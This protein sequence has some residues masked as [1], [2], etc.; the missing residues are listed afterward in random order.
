[1]VWFLEGIEKIHIMKLALLLLTA[2]SFNFLNAQE[3]EANFFYGIPFHKNAPTKLR[4][5]IYKLHEYGINFNLNLPIGE[6]EKW[7]FMGRLGTSLD[8]AYNYVSTDY[9]IPNSDPNDYLYDIRLSGGSVN[10]GIGIARDLAW[11]RLELHFRPFILAKMKNFDNQSFTG[12][13][14]DNR[15][16]VDFTQSNSRIFVETGL[17]ISRN[18]TKKMSVQLNVSM[19]F[20]EEMTYENSQKISIVNESAVISKQFN[21]EGNVDVNNL[22]FSAGLTFDL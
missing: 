8:V 18:L 15:V 5:D 14:N 11:E 22:F 3:I 17:R 12:M 16:E 6:S 21:S 13:Y 1:M 2:V 7:Y 20:L 10:L 4:G 9:K 19:D